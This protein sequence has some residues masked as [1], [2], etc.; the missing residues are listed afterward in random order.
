MA[1]QSQLS[2]LEEMSFAHVIQV[3][4]LNTVTVQKPCTKILIKMTNEQIQKATEKKRFKEILIKEELEKVEIA[5]LLCNSCTLEQ[6][7]YLKFQ[8][9]ILCKN[10]QT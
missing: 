4:K 1:S 2:K 9:K 8:A 5:T 3:K 6:M 7:R 10:V